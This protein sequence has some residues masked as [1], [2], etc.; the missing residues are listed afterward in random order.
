MFN[1]QNT[2]VDRGDKKERKSYEDLLAPSFWNIIT[3]GKY[4]IFPQRV[5]FW[6][7]IIVFFN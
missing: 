6:I 7:H 4:E 2:A 3:A 1:I 5:W